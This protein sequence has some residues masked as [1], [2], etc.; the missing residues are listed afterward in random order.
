MGK[1]SCAGARDVLSLRVLGIATKLVPNLTWKPLPQSANGQ[2]GYT[3]PNHDFDL[4]SCTE[5][6]WPSEQGCAISVSRDAEWASNG[7]G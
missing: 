6:K 7:S 1:S 2:I 3:L 5:V 4:G